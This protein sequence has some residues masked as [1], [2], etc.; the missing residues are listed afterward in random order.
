[1]LPPG[2][3]AFGHTTYERHPP[4][5]SL[6]YQL[7]E[8]HYPAM[9]NQ[10]AQQGKSLPEHI[11]IVNSI[12]ITL[13]HKHMVVQIL[14]DSRQP[15]CISRREPHP[16]G[17]GRACL[18]NSLSIVREGLWL[19]NTLQRPSATSSVARGSPGF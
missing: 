1:M 14:I 3:D 10:L 4:E 19:I 15:C 8:A 7:V 2:K 16:T 5:Q 9:V 17:P 12:T 18:K 11:H 6:L 13:I